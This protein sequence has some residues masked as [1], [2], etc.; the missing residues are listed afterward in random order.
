LPTIV[1]VNGTA[2]GIDTVSFNAFDRAMTYTL[3]DNVENL[4]LSGSTRV[5]AIGNAG[6]NWIRGTS[7]THI[8]Y[9][10]GNPTTLA[11]G[12]GSDTYRVQTVFTAV[13]EVDNSQAPGDVDTVEAQFGY[14]LPVNVE[15][16]TLVAGVLPGRWGSVDAFGNAA[17]NTITGNEQNNVLHGGGGTDTLAGGAGDDVYVIDDATDTVTGETAGVDTIRTNL[18]SID[19][20]APRYANVENVEFTGTSGATAIGSTA[21]NLLAGTAGNDSLNG[22]SGDDVLYGCGGTDTLAGGDGNDQLRS[23]FRQLPEQP[24]LAGGPVAGLRMDFHTLP[25]STAAVSAYTVYNGGLN[26]QVASGVAPVAGL[27]T[28]GYRV[29]LSGNLLISESGWYTFRAPVQGS[30]SLTVGGLRVTEGTADGLAV[31]LSRPMWL[32]AGSAF[33]T[34]PLTD[35]TGNPLSVDIS[36][37]R[38][39]TADAPIV[40]AAFVPVPA[41]NLSYGRA[42]PVDTQGDTLQGGAGNDY[43]EGA[44]GTDTLVGGTGNDTYVVQSSADIVTELAG[45]SEGT[46]DTLMATSGL[47]LDLSQ[48]AYAN[49][50]NLTL[51]GPG[52]QNGTG[53][54]GNNVLTGTRFEN[55]LSGLGGND[56]LRGNGGIDTLNGGQGD[57]VLEAASGSTLNGDEGNDTLRV[58]DPWTPDQLGAGRLAVWLDGADADGDGVREGMA[59]GGLN[60]NRL[61][62]WVDKSGNGRNGEVYGELQAPTLVQNAINGLPVV[63][64]DGGDDYIVVNGVPSSSSQIQSLFWVQNT[65]DTGYL[66]GSNQGG[67][68]GYML[69]AQNGSTQTDVNGGGYGAFSTFWK[70]GVATTWA[71]RGAVYSALHNITT[72]VAAVNQ[73]LTLGGG[74]Q[75][76][77]ASNNVSALLGTA[78]GSSYGGSIPEIILV[79]GT[80]GTT[81]RQFVEGYLAW[82]WGHQAL[83][84]ADHPYRNAAPQLATTTLGATLNG[85]DGNDNLTGGMN[86]DTLNGGTGADTMAGGAGNDT[87]VVDNP[88]DSLTEAADAGIDTVQSSIGHTLGNHVENL[89]LTGSANLNGTGNAADNS[90]TGNTGANLLQGLGGNDT[91]NGGAGADQMEGGTGNDTYVV[92]NP[93]DQVV[94]PSGADGGLDLVQAAISYTLPGLVENLTLTGTAANGTGNELANTIVGNAAA[95]V[96][97]GL[98][99]ADT[100]R[101]MGGDDTYWVDGTGGVVDVVDETSGGVD[102]GGNDQV[103]SSV[104]YTLPSFVERLVLTGGASNNAT[105]NATANVLEGNDGNNQLNGLGGDDTMTGGLGNDT[106]DGGAGNDQLEGGS[107]NDILVGGGGVD[108]LLGGA[109]NDRLA[110][111]AQTHIAQAD[112]GTGDDVLA[113]STVGGALDLA[114]LVGRVTGIEALELRDEQD[115]DILLDAATLS[116]MTDSRADLVLYLDDGDTLTIQ[117]PYE[118]TGTGIDSNTGQAYTSYRLFTGEQQSGTLHVYVPPG[119]PGP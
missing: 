28:E 18:A 101:G 89:V 46:A 112:G 26:Y 83:L 35:R 58:L 34:L 43:L 53:S 20:T 88:G 74:L 62:L 70:D 72:T 90:L 75:F 14:R 115:S 25:Q 108:T 76:G 98:G 52:A 117:S 96:L 110:F 113:L 36:W 39:D 85:G 24:W 9:S 93:L 5:N 38:N 71:T 44:G 55:V 91:L 32:E 104:S 33:I 81:E 65:T 102:Q 8:F 30:F 86:G 37:Q 12:L 67:S 100:M 54:N 63:R 6:N 11:G 42:V 106:L 19:L 116:A 40:D 114:T 15:N 57:D 95:N 61:S 2:D 87:Y 118:V 29:W 60:G 45:D 119:Q 84:P 1:E 66:M 73:P 94:E 16:L 80:M 31:S 56:T 23:G 109:G 41:A 21:A 47:N 7:G 97:D 82:K 77:F 99:G 68:T 3:P 10:G 27:P 49:I 17:N 78:N 69:A 105:G 111:D 13:Q 103:R 50:E 107:G 22:N 51:I 79:S 64:F 48:A 4:D 92:D 59:E